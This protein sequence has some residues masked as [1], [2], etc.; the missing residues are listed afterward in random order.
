MLFWLVCRVEC[1]IVYYDQVRMVQLDV[2]VLLDGSLGYN[3]EEQHILP[4]TLG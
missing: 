1:W 3:I 2:L 4:D